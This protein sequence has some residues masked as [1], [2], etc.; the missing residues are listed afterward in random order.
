MELGGYFVCNGLERVIRL[1]VQQRRHYVM[2]LRRGAYAKRGAAFTSAATLMRRARGHLAH[3]R[4]RTS[5]RFLKPAVT[6][7]N[8][9]HLRARLRSIWAAC[10]EPALMACAISKEEGAAAA[11]CCALGGA[12]GAP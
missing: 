3:P 9:R 7:R 1:L 10:T 4:G 5:W 6:T 11:R 2:A 12:H 8:G